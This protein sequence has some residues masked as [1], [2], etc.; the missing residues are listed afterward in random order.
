MKRQIFLSKL[1]AAVQKRDLFLFLAIALLIIVILQS[2]VL[3]KS[4]GNTRLVLVP[5][6]LKQTGWL[7]KRGVSA[8]YLSEMTRYYA[9]LFLNLSPDDSQQQME[10]I[11][12][13]TAPERY[14][15][16]KS[17]LLTEMENLNRKHLST[18][19]SPVS[20]TVD[21]HQLTADITGDLHVLVGKEETQVVRTTYRAHY[22]YRNGLLLIA[23]FN[24]V[25][26]EK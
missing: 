10:E 6:P 5:M 12:H 11:L 23:A 1:N 2:V 13:F 17:E 21:M 14:G 22:I 19:F 26:H 24:E 18:W 9:S 15:L 16:L 7:D 4:V 3:M 25:P 20:V 8:S